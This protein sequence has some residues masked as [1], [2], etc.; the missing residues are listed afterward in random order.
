[1]TAA[2]NGK[3]DC[4][5][6]AGEGRISGEFPVIVDYPAGLRDNHTVVISLDRIGIRNM[7]LTVRFRVMLH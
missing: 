4:W 7:Y 2:L 3:S 1:M 5:R 6:C